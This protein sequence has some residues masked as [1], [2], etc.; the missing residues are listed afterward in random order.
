MSFYNGAPNEDPKI[1]TLEERVDEEGV[2]V[3]EVP[4]LNEGALVRNKE[5]A[6][7]LIE[8]FKT[9]KIISAR[10]ILEEGGKDT[11]SLLRQADAVA[12][13][14]IAGEQAKKSA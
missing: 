12:T 6:S 2:E 5:L 1:P 10:D 11:A 14:I 4:E 8:I 3:V 7:K 13:L 9:K